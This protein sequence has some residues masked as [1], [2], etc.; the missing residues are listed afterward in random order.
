VKV[1]SIRSTLENVLRKNAPF[2]NR[3]LCRLL[4][5]GN[6]NS[7]E[8]VSISVFSAPVELKLI[9]RQ[10]PRL[11]RSGR[12]RA[13]VCWQ[14]RGGVLSPETDPRTNRSSCRLDR[15]AS[16]SLGSVCLSVCRRRSGRCPTT[17]VSSR[18]S[19]VGRAGQAACIDVQR[20]L[21]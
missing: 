8:N 10:M 3:S 20:L 1:S 9:R 18:P 4:T 5:D 15:H 7:R 21:F 2:L 16:L 12:R 6:L 13:C 11:G 19:V 14:R 17:W